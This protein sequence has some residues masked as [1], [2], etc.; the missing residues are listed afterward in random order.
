MQ[1]LKKYILWIL[2]GILILLLIFGLKMK[3]SSKEYQVMFDTDG[4]TIIRS[5]TVKENEKI[6]QPEDPVKEGYIFDGWY[7]QNQ[8]FDFET[9][10]TLDIVLKAKWIKQDQILRLDLHELSLK[11]GET[12]TLNVENTTKQK[13]KWSS[14]DKEIVT[15]DENGMVKSLKNGNATITVMT[16]DEIYKD[17]CN[18]IVTED[19]IKVV[20]V[21]IRGSSKVTVGNT[22]KLTASINP[23][24]ASNKA[25]TWKS[26]N[27]KIATVDKFGNVKGINV[28]KVTITVTTEDGK[29]TAKKT[30]AVSK[31]TSTTTSTPSEENTTSPKEESSENKEEGKKDETV[32]DETVFVKG[33]K[34]NGENNVNV[35]ETIQLIAIIDPSNATNQNVRWTSSDESIATVDEFG[36]VTGLQDGTVT[37]TVTTDDGGYSDKI[38][39]QVSTAYAIVFTKQYNNLNVLTGYNLTVYK[40]KEKW[41]GFTTIVYRGNTKKFADFFASVGEIDE[42]EKTASIKIDKTV[43]DNVPVSYQ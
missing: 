14:S 3:G 32:K 28:G 1:Y 27:E 30:I 7:Y 13:V 24:N 11:P 17:T 42:N 39:I 10:I 2:L 36:K 12:H 23:T 33:I 16:K 4:G 43:I 21:S 15:V 5:L 26:S 40:N 34:I 8:L 37:I 38:T 22:I 9:K 25:V 18:V 31:V 29:K 41:S 35:K 6:S 19:L 20:S